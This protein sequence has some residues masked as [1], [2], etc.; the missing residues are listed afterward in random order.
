M[1][2][3]MIHLLTARKVRVDAPALFLLGN[4]APDAVGARDIKDKNHL[5][6]ETDRESALRALAQCTDRADPFAEG[7]LLHLFLDY[8]WDRGPLT[9]FIHSYGEGWFLPYRNE[10]SLAGAWLYHHSAW[11]ERAWLDM[12][13][14]EAQR[15]CECRGARA[16]EIAGFLERNHRWHAANNIGPSPFYPPAFVE[17]FTGRAAENYRVWRDEFPGK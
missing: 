11:S 2:S 4:I 17:S 9:D 12:R 14:C 10:I 16:D 5:R 7:V 8:H 6:T 1:P 3:S 15:Q 13:A